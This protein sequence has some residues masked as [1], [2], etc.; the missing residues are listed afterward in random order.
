MKTGKDA[1]L[2]G[3]TIVTLA[4]AFFLLVRQSI[5]DDYKD[6]QRPSDFV[7]EGNDVLEVAAPASPTRASPNSPKGKTLQ[8]RKDKHQSPLPED[9]ARSPVPHMNAQLTPTKKCTHIYML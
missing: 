3:Q 9:S 4:C 1:E 7:C 8:N 6:L 2:E 5:F